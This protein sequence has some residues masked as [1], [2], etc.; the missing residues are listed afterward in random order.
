MKLNVDNKT[1]EIHSIHKS[2]GYYQ[3]VVDYYPGLVE[4][5]ILVFMMESGRE[6][7]SVIE[8]FEDNEEHR[9]LYVE[10]NP[11]QVTQFNKKLIKSVL[12]WGTL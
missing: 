7:L 5:G 6:V 3:V 11:N 10:I 2:G 12:L 1:L 8:S 9:I 4:E